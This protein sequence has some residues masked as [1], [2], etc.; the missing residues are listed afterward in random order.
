MTQA[1][2]NSYD[3]A[4]NALHDAEIRYGQALPYITKAVVAC[5][6]GAF[7]LGVVVCLCSMGIPPDYLPDSTEK[8]IKLSQQ[9]L[10]KCSDSKVKKA[11][12][13]PLTSAL[14]QFA[15][16]PQDGKKIV[17]QA[18]KVLKDCFIGTC[19]FVKAAYYFIDHNGVSESE[20]PE[21]IQ[22]DQS[23]KLNGEEPSLQISE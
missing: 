13:V 4:V 3:K 16:D 9:I 7:W 12:G 18:G 23:L 10:S 22:S 5:L 8:M 6:A 17:E 14:W 1:Q 21:D 2:E 15:K 19:Y 20:I 11:I